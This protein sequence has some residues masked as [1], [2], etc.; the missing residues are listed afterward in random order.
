MLAQSSLT[1][2]PR[3]APSPPLHME[4]RVTST[5]SGHLPPAMIP[6]RPPLSPAL[7][8]QENLP[9]TPLEEA[10][11][12]WGP[13]APCADSG[14]SSRESEGSEEGGGG[15]WRLNPRERGQER[16]AGAG[17]AGRAAWRSPREPFLQEGADEG[18]SRRRGRGE[19]GSNCVWGLKRSHLGPSC[20]GL[21]TSG[22]GREERQPGLAGSSWESQVAGA[23]TKMAGR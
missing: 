22:R 3:G 20:V 21:E 8:G 2:T 11:S 10:P 15:R 16:K 1:A 19:M 9:V 23:L 7:R 13:L 17:G 12:L 18:S 4:L 5:Q 6:S 14:R